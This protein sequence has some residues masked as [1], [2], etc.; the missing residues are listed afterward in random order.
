MN[1]P[2]INTEK[3]TSV[4]GDDSRLILVLDALASLAVSDKSGRVVAI[5]VRRDNDLLRFRIPENGAVKNG[6]PEYVKK[7]LR[8]LHE[9]AAASEA[10]GLGMGHAFIKAPYCY[11]LCTLYKRFM[12]YK[13]LEQFERAFVARTADEE[14]CFARILSLITVQKRRDGITMA[15]D[16]NGRDPE[17]WKRVDPAA[18]LTNRQWANL[19]FEMA[20]GVSDVEP[21]LAD[22]TLCEN[23]AEGLKGTAPHLSY[24]HSYEPSVLY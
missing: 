1:T 22:R 5:A 13:W 12:G 21:L 11:S 2:R 8:E 16:L 18:I 6:L 9:I 7:F 24:F 17:L 19:V 3:Q 14:K 23:R 10:D 20:A 15:H 4:T